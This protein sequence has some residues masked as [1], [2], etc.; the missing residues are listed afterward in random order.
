MVRFIALCLLLTCTGPVWGNGFDLYTDSTMKYNTY[1]PYSY[2]NPGGYNSCWFSLLLAS[3][4]SIL[5]TIA[6]TQCSSFTTSNV[7]TWYRV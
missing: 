6:A 7:E 2:S 1:S 3:H 4:R 5:I